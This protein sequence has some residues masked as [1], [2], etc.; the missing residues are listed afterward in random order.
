VDII[1]AIGKTEIT[2]RF[3]D[4]TN[5]QEKIYSVALHTKKKTLKL[6]KKIQK[7]N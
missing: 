3:E 6:Q 7:K 4:E 2:C 5:R 1:I